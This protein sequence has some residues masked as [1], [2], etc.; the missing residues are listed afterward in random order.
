MTYLFSVK[1]LCA[2]TDDSSAD[3]ACLHPLVRFTP[4]EAVPGSD[5]TAR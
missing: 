4:G 3:H 2:K 1:E 5:T